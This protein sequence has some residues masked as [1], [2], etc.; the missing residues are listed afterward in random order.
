MNTLPLFLALMLA[1]CKSVRCLLSTA[2]HGSSNRKSAQSRL[3]S[4]FSDLDDLMDMVLTDPDL[5]KRQRSSSNRTTSDDQSSLWKSFDWESIPVQ[6]MRPSPVETMLINDRIVYIKCDHQLRLPGSQIS[7]NKARKMLALNQVPSKDFPRVVVSYGGPQ[8][9]AMLALAAIVHFQNQT[10]T[11]QQLPPSRFVYYTKNLPKFLRNNPSGNLFRAQSLG[12]DMV[13]L[14][15][16]EYN[17]L[18]GSDWGG[19][20]EPPFAI[21]PPIPG[22]SLWIPQG[23]ANGAALPGVRRLAQEVVDYWTLNGKG[24]PLTVCVPSGSCTTSVLLHDAIQEI[25]QQ[26][27]TSNDDRTTLDIEVVVIPCVGDEFYAQRQMLALNAELGFRSG[28]PAILSPVPNGDGFQ[29]QFPNVSNNYFR[30]G[31]P[32][33]EIYD[34]YTAMKEDGLNLDLLYGAPSWTILL[35]HLTWNTLQDEPFN[36]NDEPFNPRYPFKGRSVMYIHSGGLEG[37][38]TQLLRYK[39]KGIVSENEIQN[40]GKW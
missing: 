17:N 30:F 29:K 8:S 21:Q 14:S 18:F 34:T 16:K 11:N 2:G 10:R 28:I 27:V 7:G 13:E 25:Q 4:D 36:S 5:F 32:N 6:E 31:E 26:N 24:R 38:N 22:D 40:P 15:D 33:R 1:A 9:N 23:G 35:R 20:N 37:I 12:M 19:S 3:F 39:Y